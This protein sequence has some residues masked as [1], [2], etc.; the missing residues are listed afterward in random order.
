MHSGRELIGVGVD[1]VTWD[2]VVRFLSDHSPEF[3]DRLLTEAEQNF[4][5]H[6]SH[7][8]LF[9]ARSMAAKEAF[10]K[11]SGGFW[12]GGEA[13]F[14]EIEIAMDG[15]SAFHIPGPFEAAGEFFETPRG[16][17][18]RV[19]VWGTRRHCEEPVRRRSNLKTEIALPLRGSQ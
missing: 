12:M 15:N 13:G 6:T 1:S 5:R 7:K 8:L 17:G 18:A 14:R 2:R 19:M 4:F 16:V 9:F 11:A 10:F 3:T